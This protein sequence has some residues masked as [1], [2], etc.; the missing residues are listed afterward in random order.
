VGHGME[1]SAGMRVEQGVGG[2]DGGVGRSQ[3]VRDAGGGALLC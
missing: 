3:Q 2:R 1:L